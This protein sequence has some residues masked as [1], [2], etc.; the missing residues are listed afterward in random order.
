M[1]L[2]NLDQSCRNIIAKL[3]NI[4]YNDAYDAY[5]A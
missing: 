2:K 4:D 5:D 3:L 1:Q